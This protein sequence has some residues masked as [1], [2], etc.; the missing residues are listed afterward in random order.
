M[1]E[2]E[3]T[4]DGRDALII[5]GE[6]NHFGRPQA[7]G[8][9]EIAEGDVLDLAVVREGDGVGPQQIDPPR[10]DAEFS[11]NC[12][13]HFHSRI[14][15]LDLSVSDVLVQLREQPELLA[16]GSTRIDTNR[17]TTPDERQ[18]V[19][20]LLGLLGKMVSPPCLMMLLRRP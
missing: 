4:P 5:S 6:E 15:E 2:F 17:R 7:T 14:V 10:A 19:D 20:D 12:L 11:L 3:P 8:Q 9:E 18:E 13:N 1:P 16:F